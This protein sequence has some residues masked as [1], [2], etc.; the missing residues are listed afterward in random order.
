[1]AHSV[2]LSD[3]LI[4]MLGAGLLALSGW[5]WA[6]RSRRARFW[7]GRP[8]FDQLM[9]A[10]LPGLG[11][12]IV[13]IEVGKLI[14]TSGANSLLLLLPIL[15]GAV[16]ELAGM[17]DLLPRWWGPAWYR[18]LPPDQRRSDPT[19]SSVAAAMQGYLGRPGFTSSAEARRRVGP[20]RPTASWRGGWV[21]DPDTDERP[22]AMARR[23]T[24]EGRLTLYPKG[25]VFA[26]SRAEDSLRGQS[27]V[28]LIPADEITGVQVVPPRAGADGRPRPGRL[29]RSWFPR[30]VVRTAENAHVFDVARGRAGEVAKRLAALAPEAG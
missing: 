7:V 20:A 30:L 29:Y 8:N 14:G 26:A 10:V 6:G 24:V 25:V 5:A 15:L 16:L 11:L 9:L 2:T 17:L 28:L 3:V 27:T 19:R 12:L 4:L 18:H 23:G 22:H 13:G 1:M 21:Y